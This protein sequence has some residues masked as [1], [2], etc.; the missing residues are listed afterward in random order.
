[1]KNTVKLEVGMTPRY[2]KNSNFVTSR[3]AVSKIKFRLRGAAAPPGAAR[4]SGGWVEGKL[5]IYQ[6]VQ[7]LLDPSEKV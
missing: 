2:Y 7:F 1:M 5:K 4:G 6:Q 3:G